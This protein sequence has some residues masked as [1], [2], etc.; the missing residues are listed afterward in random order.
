MTISAKTWSKSALYEK[1]LHGINMHTLNIIYRCS[2]SRQDTI[3]S[4]DCS[5]DTSFI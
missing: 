3:L 1:S 5:E 4:V 2:L